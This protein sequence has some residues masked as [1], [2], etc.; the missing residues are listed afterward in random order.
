MPAVFRQVYNGHSLV[1][2][3]VQKVNQTGNGVKVEK[4]TAL[5]TQSVAVPSVKP[6]IH[7]DQKALR[8]KLSQEL[9]KTL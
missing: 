4:S 2:R 6:V 1:L 9:F 7:M 3:K 5:P 8:S